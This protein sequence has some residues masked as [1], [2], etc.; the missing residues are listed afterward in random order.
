MEKS[1]KIIAISAFSVL[2][3]LGAFSSAYFTDSQQVSNT[4]KV[5][6]VAIDVTEANWDTRDD[7]DN[8][9]PDVVETIVPNKEF[10]K[11][12]LIKNTGINDAFVFLEVK[13]PV[14]S[15]ICADDSGA[16][17]EI[18]DQELFTML[19]VDNT[20]WQQLSHT[21]KDLEGN[22]VYV[23]G[24]KH[25]LSKD[26]STTKL[27]DK[28][29]FANIIEGQ[30]IEGEQ[31]NIEVHAMAIQA[32]ETGTMEEAFNKYLAQNN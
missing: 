2:A 16:R 14:A 7:N 23:F 19:N 5:G 29:K 30:D 12:P 20:N 9:V 24:Y 28:V 4:F 32:D 21:G 31:L 10:N 18:K 26:E 17:G 27:F 15:V 1:K 6:K 3:C 25:T 11:D 22:A 13:I 8:G